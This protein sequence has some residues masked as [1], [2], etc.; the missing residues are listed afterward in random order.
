M[1]PVKT[2]LQTEHSECGL[3]SA[4]SILN[5]FRLNSNLS[6]LR[7]HYGVPRGG[8]SLKD[9]SEILKSKGLDYRG[10]RVNDL[11]GLYSQKYPAIM[12]WD[13]S[14]YVVYC[15]HAFNYIFIMNPQI[16]KTVM[17]VAEFKTHFTGY[18]LVY[19][20]ISEQAA[21]LQPSR[22]WQA[23]KLLRKLSIHN[24]LELIIIFGCMIAL[25]LTMLVLP[26]L[27]QAIIDDSSHLSKLNVVTAL[28]A[29]ASVHFASLTTSKVL[30]VHLQ[31]CWSDKFSS[32]FI[33]RLLS[34][35]YPF[36]VNQ[37]S[38]SLI[39]KAN[40]IS[41]IQQLL[42]TNVIQNAIN[43]L[44]S[45]IYFLELYCISPIIAISV[46]LLCIFSSFFS[47]INAWWTTAISRKAMQ[48]QSDAQAV[49]A[50]MLDSIETVKSLHIEEQLFSSWKTLYA[51]SLKTT[52]KQGYLSALLSSV[53]STILSMA[54][55]FILGIGI[56]Q[57]TDGL[58]TIGSLAASLSLTSYMCDPFGL[59]IDS[60]VQWA[61]IKVLLDQINEIINGS[62]G[63]EANYSS[64]D[65]TAKRVA[66]INMRNVSFRYSLFDHDVIRSASLKINQGDKIGVVGRSGSGKS[67][68]LKILAGLLSPTSGT[69]SIN[70]N[71]DHAKLDDRAIAYLPQRPSV[72]G[73][74]LA[75]NLM[76]DSSPLDE[77]QR[78]LILEA[79]GI[80]EIA[81]SS[82]S[83]FNQILSE[84][85]KNLSGGQVQRIALARCLL[86]DP[87]I[88]I[89]DEPTSAM[90]SISERA[91]IDYLIK[92]D[93]TII[94]TAHRLG[95][96]QKFGRILVMEDGAIKE[97]GSVSSLLQQAG[98]YAS[99]HRAQNTTDQDSGDFHLA[100]NPH[101][102]SVLESHGHN[103]IAI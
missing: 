14:H 25:R 88:I 5:Y 70:D 94:L 77:H 84:G 28:F 57:F 21:E 93:K 16:G 9:L 60:I 27:T 45:L 74:S 90:D 44:F 65:D 68:L 51:S 69:L 79:T 7:D 99:L 59:L 96:I 98:I 63:I 46:C 100:N 58:L 18:A 91:I 37:A 11:K 6:S 75:D 49:I 72:F 47:I 42:T 30:L 55:L 33:E 48:E 38:G 34:K 20:G 10:V 29:C 80:F 102:N 24:L 1:K 97:E 50:E 40:L 32:T 54:P 39:Y 35:R 82:A 15:G 4:A 86:L 53:S 89:M 78:N 41:T 61:S 22:T 73:K 17:P 95:T 71:N 23:P 19:S 101:P 12:L 62:S 87:D 36:F 43:L 76:L 67:T 103:G 66:S 83:K 26:I 13:N 31:K 85:G 56:S 3:A 52:A 2:I 92:S 81:N 8:L 64:G